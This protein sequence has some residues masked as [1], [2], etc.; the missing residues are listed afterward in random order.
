MSIFLMF[1]V[2]NYIHAQSEITG[3]WKNE[4]TGSVIE[5]DKQNNMFYGK[6]IKV[7]GNEPKEKLGHILYEK[8]IFNYSTNDYQGNVNSIT[9][10]KADCELELIGQN[11]FRMT[12]NRLF[13]KK[14]QTYVR[15]E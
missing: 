11:R 3:K 12:V 7:M 14:N 1:F 13:I 8:L 2:G 6:I 9:G 10:M 4:K 5:I 15:T